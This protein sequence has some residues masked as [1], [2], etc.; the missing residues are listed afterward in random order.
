MKV[1][2]EP[3]VVGNSQR[4]V[5]VFLRVSIEF[6]AVFHP[7]H[8]LA[9]EDVREFV[10]LFIL[11]IPSR[12]IHLIQRR[13]QG[14]RQDILAVGH[15]GHDSA[16]VGNQCAGDEG[17]PDFELVVHRVTSVQERCEIGNQ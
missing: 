14:I 16:C 13:R 7:L 4:R 2:F 6:C 5:R 15:I 17:E 1:E 12:P 8:V 11:T 10:E 9:V 3:F